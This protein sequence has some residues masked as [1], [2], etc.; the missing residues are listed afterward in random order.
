MKSKGR[1]VFPGIINDS[2]PSRS[3]PTAAHR[4]TSTHP[5]TDTGATPSHETDRSR[6]RPGFSIV[7]PTQLRSTDDPG[8]KYPTQ[9]RSSPLVSQRSALSTKSKPDQARLYRLRTRC[10]SSAISI[11]PRTY[12]SWSAR[13]A[14]VLRHLREHYWFEQRRW[15]AHDHLMVFVPTFDTSSTPSY[16]RAHPLG[17]SSRQ[18]YGSAP[19]HGEARCRRRFQIPTPS[20]VDMIDLT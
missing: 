9:S 11:S 7:A 2:S 13:A 4:P 12:A 8:K 17:E 18:A 16:R 1:T 3:Q 6:R 19:H 20:R 14:S 15:P 5:G 10:P